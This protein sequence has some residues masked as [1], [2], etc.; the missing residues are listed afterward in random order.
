VLLLNGCLLLLLFI[1]LSTHSRLCNHWIWCAGKITTKIHV[2]SNVR[3][4]SNADRWFWCI[5][6]QYA[7]I[8]SVVEWSLGSRTRDFGAPKKK[9]NTVTAVSMHW[10]VIRILSTHARWESIFP[11]RRNIIM[12]FNH[13][14]RNAPRMNNVQPV[15]LAHESRLQSTVKWNINRK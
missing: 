13:C 2:F 15:S 7:C 10:R 6:C 12:H 8:I 4:S 11:Y 14:L 1:S 5:L 3:F 9:K